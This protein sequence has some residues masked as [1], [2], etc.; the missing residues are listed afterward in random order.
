MADQ[1]LHGNG[2]LAP[3]RLIAARARPLTPQIFRASS[4]PQDRSAP[5]P[6][7]PKPEAGSLTGS[8]LRSNWQLA[9]LWIFVGL[10]F[11][12]FVYAACLLWAKCRGASLF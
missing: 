6:A 7:A 10:S 5:P 9:V 4:P 2:S 8:T 11:V 3:P 12:A 1:H